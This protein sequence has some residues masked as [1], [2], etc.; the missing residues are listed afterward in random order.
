MES[1]HPTFGNG[2]I[3]YIEIPSEDLNISSSFYQ[4]VFNWQVRKRGD[5]TVSF[6]DS[7]NEVSGSWVLGRKSEDTLRNIVSNGGKVVQDIG[8]DF[9]EITARFEDPYRNILGI[10]Q[11]RS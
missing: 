4:N 8:A 6:D 9:P 3:C 11:H 2:K 7:I 1:N 10:Y 5:G